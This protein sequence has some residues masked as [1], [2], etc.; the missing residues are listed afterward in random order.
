MAKKKS[1]SAERQAGQ[2][3]A[4]RDSALLRAFS[5]ALLL[6]KTAVAAL[7]LAICWLAPLVPA[8]L[9]NLASVKTQGIV[10]AAIAIG[11][12]VAA[13]LAVESAF[14]SRDAGR[15]IISALLA[16]FFV[17]A[18]M[19]TALSNVS[20]GSEQSRG[21]RE[22]EIRQRGRDETR[23]KELSK[24]RKAQLEIAGNATPGSIEAEIQAAKA[25][26]APRWRATEG[27][28]PEKISAGPSRAFCANLAQLAAKKAAALKRDQLDIQL[29]ALDAKDGSAVPQSADPGAENMAAT[30]ESFG[31]TVGKNGRKI[32]SLLSD[33]KWAIGVELIAAFFP[34]LL[35]AKLRSLIA[36]R[37]G[38]DLP[39]PKPQPKAP[40]MPDEKNAAIAAEQDKTKEEPPAAVEKPR[41]KPAPPEDPMAAFLA[42]ATK[43]VP[44]SRSEAKGDLNCLCPLHRHDEPDMRVSI[45]A[46]IADRLRPA[47]E[48]VRRRRRVWLWR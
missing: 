45:D 10:M 27:C 1:V 38:A 17:S 48:S 43:R 8:T 44:G 20:T 4:P 15:R 47:A 2:V 42:W 22:Q 11:F 26:D 19:H 35:Q 41:R 40:V 28:T 23:F 9:I 5:A 32:L 14:E 30:L 25:T 18:N 34:M 33:W 16:M 12:V 7:A 13:A 29:D 37:K 36:P 3:P 31:L 46:P 21:T 24:S 6:A 39:L